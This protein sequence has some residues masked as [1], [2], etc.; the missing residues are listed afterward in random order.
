MTWPIAK[1]PA[2]VGAI[3][4][5]ASQTE[6]RTGA[7]ERV[8]D[9]RAYDGYHLRDMPDRF[10]FIR[11]PRT[12][13]DWAKTEVAMTRK[14][15]ER[16]SHRALFPSGSCTSRPCSNGSVHGTDGGL[17]SA[18]CSHRLR[19]TDKKFERTAVITRQEQPSPANLPRLDDRGVHRGTQPTWARRS[20]LRWIDSPRRR[21]RFRRLFRLIDIAS[22]RA[23]RSMQGLHACPEER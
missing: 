14:G 22:C 2:P 8:R 13:S 11:P 10:L 3:I 6:A 9:A 12:R 15:Q 19:P 18:P 1:G 5:R 4:S 21:V 23:C 7:P 16:D 20:N 17:R